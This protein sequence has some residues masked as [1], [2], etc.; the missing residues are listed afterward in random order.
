MCSKTVR[1]QRLYK[2]TFKSTTGFIQFSVILFNKINNLSK[3]YKILPVFRPEKMKKKIHQK[4][5]NILFLIQS[6]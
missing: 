4:F 5:K 6:V 1:I 3:L 2:N